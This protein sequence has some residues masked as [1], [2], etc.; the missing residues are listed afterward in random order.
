MICHKFEHVQISELV[1]VAMIRMNKHETQM[2]LL[3]LQT[4][5]LY[6]N[7]WKVTVDNLNAELIFENQ[8]KWS[9]VLM[10][11]SSLQSTSTG[12]IKQVVDKIN[13]NI[14]AS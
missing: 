8:Q 9:E 12:K 4:L 3:C 1:L 5:W 10:H 2:K 14:D 7:W 6:G 11:W 13:L